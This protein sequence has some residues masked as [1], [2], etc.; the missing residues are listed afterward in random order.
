MIVNGVNLLKEVLV[1]QIFGH[2]DLKNLWPMLSLTSVFVIFSGLVDI[3]GKR[4]LSKRYCHCKVSS[5]SRDIRNTTA[6]IDQW[7]TPCGVPS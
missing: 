7:K 5:H 4:M 6:D 2:V 1:F 3:E